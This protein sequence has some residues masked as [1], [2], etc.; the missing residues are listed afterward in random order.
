MLAIGV[1][2]LRMRMMADFTTLGSDDHCMK[3]LR[4]A[5]KSETLVCYPA[6]RSSLPHQN[7]IIEKEECSGHG[8]ARP[9]SRGN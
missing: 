1:L 4:I 9:V 2:V 6:E 7:L 8:V 5:H 3:Y